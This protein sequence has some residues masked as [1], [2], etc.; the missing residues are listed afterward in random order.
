MSGKA[1][2]CRQRFLYIEAYFERPL[3]DKKTEES[4]MIKSLDKMVRVIGIIIIPVGAVLLVQEWF[5][6]EGGFRDSVI[7]MVAAV[8]GMIPE[9]LYMTASIA[10]VISAMNLRAATCLCRT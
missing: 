10:M 3:K 8:L 9:G 7:S 4:E 2:S 1:H 5:V 6:L